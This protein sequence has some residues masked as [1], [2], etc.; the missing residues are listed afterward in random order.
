MQALG[1][2]EFLELGPGGVLTGLV[3]R[4]LKGVKATSLPTVEAVRKYT[5][6]AG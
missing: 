2:A 4:T 6:P 5:A 3:G 1:A